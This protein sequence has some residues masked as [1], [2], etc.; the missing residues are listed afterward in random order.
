MIR[1]VIFD[2]GRVLLGF[3]WDRYVHMLFDDEAT[4]R[5]VT[6]ASFRCPY[7]TEMDRGNMRQEDIVENMIENAPDYSAQILEAVERVGECVERFD[8]AIPWIEDLKNR[9]YQVLY[10]SNYSEHVRARSMHAM[11]FLDRTDGGIFS[12]EVKSVKPEPEIFEMLIDRFDLVPEEC[13]FIDD[14]F[15][16]VETAVGLGFNTIL[17]K[18]YEQ[19]SAELASV[20]VCACGNAAPEAEDISDITQELFDSIKF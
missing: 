13:V 2:I 16:N 3:E 19:A 1:T 9:G 14:S 12:Y 11:D 15:P 18:N 20:L 17:F 10:L 7:W 4:C 8:Y 5:A 6:E